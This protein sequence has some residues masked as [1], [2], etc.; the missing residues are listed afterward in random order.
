V[1]GVT[2]I[3]PPDPEIANAM[4]APAPNGLRVLPP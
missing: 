2:G 3:T 4:H 1:L